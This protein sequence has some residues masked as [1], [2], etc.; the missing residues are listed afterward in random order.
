MSNT[1][2]ITG[3]ASGMDTDTTVKQLMKAY[4]TRLDSIKQDRQTIQWRQDL[5]RELLGEMNTF[6]SS[7]FDVLKKENYMLSGS[8]YNTFDT[9]YPTSNDSTIVTAVGGAG[10]LNGTYKLKDITLAKTASTKD[11]SAIQTI[12]QGFNSVSIKPVINGANNTI[13][14]NGKNI[15]IDTNTYDNMSALASNINTKLK[16]SKID[17][18]SAQ[19]TKDGTGIEFKP[20][21]TLTSDQNIKI[22]V[23]GKEYNVTLKS[24]IYTMEQMADSINTQIASFKDG[25]TG[26]KLILGKVQASAIYDGTNS[27][28]IFEKLDSASVVTVANGA[29]TKEIDAANKELGVAWSSASVTVAGKNGDGVTDISSNSIDE[30]DTMKFKINFTAGVNDKLNFK[31]GNDSYEITID[32]SKSY[33][34]TGLDK[35]TGLI[36]QINEQLKSAS[37]N[38]GA[39][40][41]ITSKLAAQLSPDGTR[42]QFVNKEPSSQ[43]NFSGSA[44][45]SIGF[46]STTTGIY[47]SSYDKMSSL[48]KG[49]VSFTINDK[50]ITYNFSG[51]DKDKTIND[52]MNDISSRAGVKT[53]Y[54]EIAKKFTIETNDT[55]ADQKLKVQWDTSDTASVDFL[56]KTFGITETIAGLGTFEKT[57]N[58]ATVKITDPK[59]ESA[60]ITQSKNSFSI[61]GVTYNLLQ[62]TYSTPDKEMS[63]T[64]TQNTQKSFDKIKDF[65]T[66]YNDLINKINTKLTEKHDRNYKPLTDEEKT[67]MKEDQ[68]KQW[69]DKAKQGLLKNDNDLQNM[70]YSLRSAIYQ[71]VDGV[72]ISLTD[73][74]ISTSQDYMAG[75]KLVIDE[76]KL[77]N[78]LANNGDEVAKLFTKTSSSQSMYT[79]SLTPNERNTRN[80][81]EGILQRVNDIFKD[82]TRTVDGKGSLLKKA[83]IKGDRTE[84]QNLLSDQL[85]EKDKAIKAMLTKISDKETKY[86]KQFAN[87]EVYM[88]QMNAQSSWLTQQLGT[89]S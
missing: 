51:A 3:M 68:I 17:N 42:I 64:L 71:S 33:D 69:E 84:I 74:G 32:T 86:Y 89:N 52:I 37:K 34:L 65:V 11:V 22:S 46:S 73:I 70:L 2:R 75:G 4:T 47:P 13:N 62:E 24:G 16:D 43:M 80:S 30:R 58:D 59:G 53:S 76:A 19:V 55:G 25:K 21:Q 66:K 44:M 26:E 36:Q 14:I 82:Y 7:Y 54:S 20:V 63:I 49:V 39:G 35:D 1:L 87:L 6:Q 83:G 38:G 67:A 15:T 78:A 57:G 61:D 72:G 85:K 31:I 40:E 18:V 29:V 48:V 23:D 27:K 77:K 5:Y 9:T 8:S 88:N 45:S 50:K 60:T 79:S 28:L 41:D 10:A 12:K 81:E 56:N